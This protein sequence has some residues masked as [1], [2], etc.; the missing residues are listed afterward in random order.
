MSVPFTS[1][2][3]DHAATTPT[4]PEVIAAMTAVLG[5]SPPLGNPSSQHAA[6]RRAAATIDQARTELATLVGAAAEQIVFTSGATEA[7]N[8][9][10]LGIARGR[11][12]FGRHLVVS[13]IEHKAVLDPARRLE[14][15]GWQVSWL[16][17]TRDGR[18]TPA[19][20]A[21]AIRPDTQLVSIMHANNETGVVQ[22]LPA[23]VR[24]ARERG[25]LFHTDGAQTVGKC[26][27]DFS[28]WDLDLLSVSAH[29]FYGPAG[30]G[31]LVV[32]SRARPWLEPLMS[33]GGQER[34]LRPGTLPTALIAGLGVAA[35]LARA[36]MADDARELEIL[37]QRLKTALVSLPGLRFNDHPH[38]RLP[39]LV[40]LSIEGVEG[41]S[42]L[43]ALPDLHLS[44][45]A[46]CDSATGEPSSVLRAQGVPT[47]LAQATLRISFGRGNV[48]Q[49]VDRAAESIRR[50]VLDLRAE[51]APGLPPG[52][53]WRVG[54]A[55]TLREGAKVRAY[56]QVDR[57][58]RIATLVFRAAACPDT[59]RAMSALVA[60]APGVDLR[61]LAGLGTPLEWQREWGVPIE[62]LGRLLVVEDAVR[63]A[64]AASPLES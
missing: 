10:V 14:R 61:T 33:G 50:V 32:S 45:G 44:S 24:I 26:P 52:E 11:A 34:G 58:G 31:A 64:G 5:A 54:E 59:R 35:R 6:G 27:L 62:K 7:D 3:L 16:E 29:K 12:S 17:P 2:Y 22:D 38:A 56:L 57:A 8:L 1:I 15:A 28:A 51:D 13:T 42:L 30:I 46:A 41:E 40:S 4:D 18:I 9:A 47:E 20:L 21:A 48:A 49:D 60:R 39:G 25:V 23:L 37:A 36:R 55:G 63:R 43:A 19:A 53:G